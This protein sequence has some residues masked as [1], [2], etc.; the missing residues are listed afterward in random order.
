MISPLLAA[1]EG[2]DAD[3]QGRQQGQEEGGLD[4]VAHTPM[5]AAIRLKKGQER[6]PVD[7]Q[8]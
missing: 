4:G 2:A 3:E 8:S 6:R 5:M 1:E 7:C